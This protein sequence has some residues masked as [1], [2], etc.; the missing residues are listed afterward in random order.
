MTVCKATFS[1]TVFRGPEKRFTQNNIPISFLTLLVD[2]NE[3]LKLR[4]I[5]MGKTAETVEKE[6][7][8]DDRVVMEG[9]LRIGSGKDEEGNEVRAME[10]D[11]SSFEKIGGSI[12]QSA[13]PKEIAN[14]S[15]DDYTDDLIGEDEVPF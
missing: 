6:L 14:F 10:L 9:R 5:S 12:A 7:S 15:E 3:N 4:V 11:L 8:K 1:G 13:A 2:G